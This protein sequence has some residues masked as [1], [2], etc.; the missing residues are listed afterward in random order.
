MS[1]PK[2]VLF[3]GLF[4]LVFAV[5]FFVGFLYWNFIFSKA[6]N[7]KS[8]VVYEVTPQKTFMTIAK[9][10][11]EKNLIKNAQF[12]NVYAR[13][14]GLRS[15]IKV[16]EYQLS[17]DMRPSEI[18]NVLVSGKSMFRPFTI[19]EGYNLF[20]IAELVEKYKLGTKDEFLRLVF[21]K[22]FINELYADKLI[23]SADILSLEGY[24]YPETYQVTKY[25]GLKDII[26]TQVRL[27]R[28]NFD[29]IIRQNKIS[30][31]DASQILILASIIEKETGNAKERPL[32]SSVFHNRI[33]K[34]MKLQ[35]DPTTLYGKSM[36]SKKL[37]NNI[38]RADLTAK[39]N[40]YNTYMIP[41]LPPGPISNP[42]RDSLMAAIEPAQTPFLFFVSQNDGTT[43]F[44]ESLLEH[45]RNVQETQLD[46]KARQGKSWRDLKQ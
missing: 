20:E 44:T 4:S 28:R 30:Y 5:C 3:L 40:I 41:F 15:K 31:L 9:E 46:P 19:P 18:L 23:L 24:L 32:I 45:N 42:G 43:R 7:D 36:L 29:D 13:V 38:T 39:D 35:T 22:Q 2:R 11:E 14:I 16:G 37:E 27:F 34:K 33:A 12:F 26:R 17:T 25:M 10:L 8:D 21:D 1:K 6:T